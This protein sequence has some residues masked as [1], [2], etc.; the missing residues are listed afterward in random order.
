MDAVLSQPLCGPGEHLFLPPGVQNR[1]TVFPLVFQHL[2]DCCH[3][4]LKKRSDLRVHL[5]DFGSRLLQL[6]HPTRLPY[7]F[8][9]VL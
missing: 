8:S 4:P 2:F 9:L 6:I 1:Q 5:V 3:P 7:G